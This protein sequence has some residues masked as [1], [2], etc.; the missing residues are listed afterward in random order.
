MFYDDAGGL[1]RVLI[2]GT[3]AYVWLILILRVTGKRSLAQLN[4]FIVIVTVAIGST[5]ASVIVT[6]TVALAEGMVALSL[7]EVLQLVVAWLSVRS[8]ALQHA[9]TAAPTFLLRDGQ[10]LPATW[11]NSGSPG[12]SC[13]RPSAA[14]GSAAGAG[15]RGGT[16]DQ[17]KISVI[18][19]GQAGSGS[20][21]ANVPDPPNATTR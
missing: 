18:G 14:A 1:L 20:A 15:R 12:K 21:L 13:C 9:V 8:P 5:L 7:L 6:T 10:V 16:G 11:S 19:R 3:L 2:A 4:A 17:G